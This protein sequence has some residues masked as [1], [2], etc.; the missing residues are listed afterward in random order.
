M[1]EFLVGLIFFI[2]A[3]PLFLLLFMVVTFLIFPILILMIPAAILY[4]I[5]K[6]FGI[7]TDDK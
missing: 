2:C 5:C 6:L 4:G 1:I 7:K 3:I